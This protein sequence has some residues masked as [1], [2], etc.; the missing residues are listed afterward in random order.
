M[1][2]VIVVKKKSLSFTKSRYQDSTWELIF[3]TKIIILNIQ[4]HKAWSYAFYPIATSLYKIII[5][6][7]EDKGDTDF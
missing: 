7:A 3:Q 4:K 6:P 2:I 5:L 1:R